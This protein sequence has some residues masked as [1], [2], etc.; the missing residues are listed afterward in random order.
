MDQDHLAGHIETISTRTSTEMR[1]LIW[2]LQ[3]R[4]W[5][6]GGPDRSEPAAAE[7]VRLWGSRALDDPV[8]KCS[9]ETGRCGLCN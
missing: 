8:L 6:T 2:T 9:C 1:Q 3:L 7:W 5:P 4:C